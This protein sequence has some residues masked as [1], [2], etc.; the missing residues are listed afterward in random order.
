MGRKKKFHLANDEN[1][2]ENIVTEKVKQETQ[3]EKKEFEVFGENIILSKIDFINY[4][5]ISN[6]MLFLEFHL[7]GRF[8]D[9]GKY[10]INKDIKKDLVRVAKEI[11]D[12][13]D[14]GFV[15]TASFAKVIFHFEVEISYLEDK[16]RANLFIVEK[17]ENRTIKTL[18]D[19]FEDVNDLNFRIKTRERFNLVDVA[20]LCRD[21]EVPNLSIWLYWQNEEAQYW[22]DLYEMGSQFF[23]MRALKILEKYGQ[24]GAKIIKRYNEILIAAENE[25]QKKSYAESKE[26]LDDVINS[27]GGIEK[28]D[29]EKGELKELVKAFNKPFFVQEKTETK[30]REVIP[31]K[32]S[33]KTAKKEEPGYGWGDNSKS[34]KGGEVKKK[35]KGKEEKKKGSSN[36]AKPEKKKD[37]GRAGWEPPK[38]D[39]EQKD[40]QPDREKD[41]QLDKVER[42]SDPHEIEERKKKILKREETKTISKKEQKNLLNELDE[43]EVITEEKPNDITGARGREYLYVSSKEKPDIIEME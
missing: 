28:V 23:V 5:K 33:D 38:R 29:Q 40:R 26:V 32:K 4:Q 24:T 6:K 21:D 1:I 36:K 12:E 27:F 14:R 7:M 41:K 34:S 13:D 37:S 2:K 42:R 9:K 10:Y 35:T 43:T 22:H 16:A 18:V 17:V 31:I 8:D 15:A 20:I 30:V 19:S 3:E 39:K 11:Q 25:G